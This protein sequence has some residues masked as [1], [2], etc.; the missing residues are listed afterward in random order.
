[1]NFRK[2][3]PILGVLVVAAAAALFYKNYVGKG[4]EGPG[5]AQLLTV[6]ADDIVLGSRDAPVTIFEYASLTCPHCARFAIDT[7]PQIQAAYIDTG[8]AKLVFRDFPL[9]T[10][11]LK[12]AAL[13]H[14][15]GPERYYGFLEVLFHNQPQWSRADDPA[16]A[17][18]GIA[19]MGGMGRDEFERCINDDALA[20]RISKTR[21]DAE[22]ALTIESTPT[23]FIGG[24]KLVGT[25]PFEAFQ[26]A[27]ENSLAGS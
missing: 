15:A 4:P 27:I 17:L 25:Q 13:A 2:I 8:K 9:D 20:Q 11:A 10:W 26:A 1:M 14:C 6:T 3:L 18:A 24:E 7:L 22:K 23:F 19:K 5:A 12:A 21:F 16:A